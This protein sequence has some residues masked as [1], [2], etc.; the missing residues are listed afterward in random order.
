MFDGQGG[1]SKEEPPCRINHKVGTAQVGTTQ[2]GT[3]QVGT[4]QVPTVLP[5]FFF[6]FVQTVNRRQ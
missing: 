1:E 5:E 3:T 2:V 4:T 6:G